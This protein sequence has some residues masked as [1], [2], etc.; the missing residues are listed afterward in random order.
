MVRMEFKPEDNG[1]SGRLKEEFL[2]FFWPKIFFI[3]H[4][5]DGSSSP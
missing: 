3:S 5:N 4:R 1:E 2:N